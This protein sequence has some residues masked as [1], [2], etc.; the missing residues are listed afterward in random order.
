MDKGFFLPKHV[1]GTMALSL[2]C[3]L[4]LRVP[5]YYA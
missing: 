3:H 2:V 5:G 1:I 4:A